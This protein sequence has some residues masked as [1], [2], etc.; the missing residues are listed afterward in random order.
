MNALSFD[1]IKS[2]TLAL[3]S[4]CQRE[5]WA[6]YDPYDALNSRLFAATPFYRSKYCRIAL[7]QMLKRLPINIR[8]VL[9]IDKEQNPKAIALFLMAFI[10][11]KKL[12]LLPDERLIQTMVDR[13]IAL[14]SPDA[15][16]ASNL[17]PST[18]RQYFCWGYSFPWQGREVLVPRGA[19]NLVCTVFVANALM[20]LHESTISIEPSR[21]NTQ[22]P[23][24]NTQYFD[25]ALS[26]ADYIAN[27][28]YWEDDEAVGFSYPLPSVRAKV[29]NANFLTAALLCRVWKHT[30]NGRYLEPALRAARYSAGRQNADGSWYYGEHPKQHWIDNIHTGYNLCALQS[31]ANDTGTTEF[32]SHITQ[33]LRFYQ[34][35]FFEPDG[36]AKYFDNRRYPIDTHSIA[37]SIITLTSLR[38]HGDNQPLVSS[39]CQWAQSNMCNGNGYFFYRR[40]AYLTNRISYMRWSQAW[41]LL[42]LSIVLESML[43][44]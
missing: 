30:R 9:R 43:D 4:Y 14:R 23:T 38:N 11:L 25:M 12:G 22:H 10:K 27:E 5:N 40:L 37:Q 16:L 33:G 34:N 29:H 15:F 6:G 3:L 17:L 20:D 42:A 7:T 35:R 44:G 32:N 21:S 36:A 2:T 1:D 24:P 19:P 39:V 31:I 8:P 41:M 13:L 18:S 26:A 28:L